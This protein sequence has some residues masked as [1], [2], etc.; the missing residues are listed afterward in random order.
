M[1]LDFSDRR[2]RDLYNLAIRTK[3]FNARSCEGLSCLHAANSSSNSTAVGGDN[4]DI[5][6][7]VEGL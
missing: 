4:L 7:A 5:V 3:H 6:F 2:E 1:S